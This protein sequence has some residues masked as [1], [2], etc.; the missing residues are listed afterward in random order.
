MR[1]SASEMGMAAPAVLMMVLPGCGGEGGPSGVLAPQGDVP[2]TLVGKIAFQSNRAD[3]ANEI[4][5]MK[6][7]GTGVTRLTR[8]PGDDRSPSWSPDGTRIAFESTRDGNYE[9]YTMNADGTGPQ[10]LTQNAALDRQPD[11]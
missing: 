10:R 6:A 8:S 4:Y 7:D 3:P 1:T 11:W 2:Q 9:I 5:V